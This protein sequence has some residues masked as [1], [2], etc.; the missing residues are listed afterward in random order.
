MLDSVPFELEGSKELTDF[1]CPKKKEK[2]TG[3]LCKIQIGNVLGPEIEAHYDSVPFILDHPPTTMG[4]PRLGGC[5]PCVNLSPPTSIL[6][7]LSTEQDVRPV[8]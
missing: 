3:R 7:W 8:L 2:G 6:K 1:V 4:G 5:G